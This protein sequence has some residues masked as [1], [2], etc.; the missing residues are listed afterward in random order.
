MPPR[1]TGLPRAGQLPGQ[2]KAEVDDGERKVDSALQLQNE[3]SPV[4]LSAH[5]LLT[6]S[7]LI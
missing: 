6:I 3:Y 4:Q 5:P 2:A 1:E 7:A